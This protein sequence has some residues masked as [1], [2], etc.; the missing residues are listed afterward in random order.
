MLTL[1]FLEVT[2]V[3]SSTTLQV[4]GIVEDLDKDMFERSE[5][6]PFTFVMLV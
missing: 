6:R 1:V 2:E 4:T 5:Y 3:Y